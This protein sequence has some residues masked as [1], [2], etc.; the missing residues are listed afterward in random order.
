MLRIYRSKLFSDQS[1]LK[2]N[3]VAIRP[4]LL[5]EYDEQT[6]GT[7]RRTNRIAQKRAAGCGDIY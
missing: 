4:M 7:D 3:N 2:N 5:G 6:N 1:L